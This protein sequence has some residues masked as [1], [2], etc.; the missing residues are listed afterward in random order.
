MTSDWDCLK[1]ARQG[2]ESAWRDLFGRHQAS[3]LNMAALITGSLDSAQDVTQ[4][5]FLRLL[6]DRGENST[7]SFK[8]YVAKIAY[9]LAIKEKTRQLRRSGLENLDV[10][11]GNPSALETAIRDDRQRQIARAIRSL[12]EDQRNILIL[13]FY[14]EFSYE[15]IAEIT[16]IPLGTVKS[17]IFYAVK[18]CRERL[19]MK[20]LD[21]ETL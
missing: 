15:Q 16:R 21:H 19:M 1:R 13:R 6:K 5:S 4:E 11:D 8:A 7:G 2:D 14:G 9:H 3:L 18:A 10:S 20:G 12:A 17:R